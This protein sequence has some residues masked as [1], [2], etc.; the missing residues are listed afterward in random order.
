MSVLREEYRTTCN[1]RKNTETGT[2][3]ENVSRAHRHTH[4]RLP[5]VYSVWDTILWGYNICTLRTNS[6]GT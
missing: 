4:T 2:E 1:K 3:I 6:L 5:H